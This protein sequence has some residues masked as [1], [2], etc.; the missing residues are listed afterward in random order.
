M[1][2]LAKVS[3]CVPT[4]N[5]ELYLEQTLLTIENQ[6]YPNVE[7]IIADNCSSDGT[8]AIIE[9]FAKKNNWT[10][11]LNENNIGAG[12]NMN[13]LISSASGDFIA[14]YHSDDLYD[15]EIIAKS[16]SFLDTNPTCG[17]VS[18]LAT[19]IDSNGKELGDLGLP[20]SLKSKNRYVFDFEEIFSAILDSFVAF[21]I[22]PTV[23]VRK[24]V[25]ES[26]G[27]FKIHEKYKSAGDYEMWLRIL[28]HFPAGIIPEF[29]IKYRKHAQQGSQTEIRENYGLPDGLIVYE[30]YA[31]GNSYLEKKYKRAYSYL[32]MLQVLKL[33]DRRDFQNSKQM[34]KLIE[35]NGTF[36]YIALA[37]LFNLLNYSHI[38]FNIQYLD[39]LKS[40]FF[41]SKVK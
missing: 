21:L 7:V 33:N 6:T 8:I 9:R 23:M 3:V 35:R 26:L 39:R 28:R 2:N 36:K 10:Y 38:R 24:S 19:V 27:H 20:Q 4:Y 25:Y 29:L 22:T 30:E 32:L 16:V 14:V 34:V 15:A 31:K 40:R 18:T 1:K 11:I 12:L 13:K 5:S 37:S 17:M 41:S